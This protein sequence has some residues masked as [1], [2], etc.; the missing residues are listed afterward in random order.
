MLSAKNQG[1]ALS[2]VTTGSGLVALAAYGLSPVSREALSI[3][4]GGLGTV[5]R[6]EISVENS[7]SHPTDLDQKAK[8]TKAFPRS[9]AQRAQHE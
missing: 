2:H 3:H 9:F 6:Q 4:G 5:H 8:L 7:S 1:Y